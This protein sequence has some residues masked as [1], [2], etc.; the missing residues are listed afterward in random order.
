VRAIAER[1]ELLAICYGHAGDGNIHVNIVQPKGERERWLARREAA[2]EEV[3]R[4][5]VGLGG[6]IT[7]EAPRRCATWGCGTRP[8]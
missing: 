6:T 2:V 8:R 3:F 7:G 4:A 5:V 1:H